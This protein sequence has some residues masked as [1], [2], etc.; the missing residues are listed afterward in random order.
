MLKKGKKRTLK[1]S[2]SDK[3]SNMPIE[4]CDEEVYLTELDGKKSV[5]LNRL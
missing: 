2:K 4:I 1:D 5:H 3:N